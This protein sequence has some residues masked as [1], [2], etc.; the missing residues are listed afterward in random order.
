MLHGIVYKV[1]AN[2]NLDTV[3]HDDT[4]RIKN[5]VITEDP[6]VKL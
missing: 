6:F 4:N 1:N 2:K 3:A 5:T